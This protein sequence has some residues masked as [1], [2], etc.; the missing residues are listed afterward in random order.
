MPQFK[1]PVVNKTT[2]R[3]NRKQVFWLVNFD[4]TQKQKDNMPIEDMPWLL[5]KPLYGF[6]CDPIV[7][8]ELVIRQRVFRVTKR[9]QYPTKRNSQDGKYVGEVVVQLTD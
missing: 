4:L 9:R 3:I 5:K 8:E 6:Y 2:L 7:G 1:V